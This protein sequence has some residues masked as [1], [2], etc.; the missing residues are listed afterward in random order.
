MAD[1]ERVVMNGMDLDAAAL[2]KARAL[3][4]AIGESQAFRAFEAAQE[5]LMAD[6]EVDRRIQAFQQRQQELQLARAWGGADPLEE[7]A[8]AEEW[9]KLSLLPALRTYLRA[10][11]EVTALLREVAGAISQE[12]GV[13]FGA[14]CAPGGGCC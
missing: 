1:P 7:E 3:A 8:L 11:E 9:R 13:D 6:G 5:A 10:Q 2:E 14:A 4:R 12:I